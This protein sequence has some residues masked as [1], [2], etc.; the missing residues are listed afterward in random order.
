MI[1]L[2]RVSRVPGTWFISAKIRVIT[3]NTHQA[4]PR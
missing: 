2:L 4:K 1:L 3:Q